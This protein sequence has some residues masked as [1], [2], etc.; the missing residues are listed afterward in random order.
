M[1]QLLNPRPA[2]DA[3]QTGRLTK[4]LQLSRQTLFELDVTITAYVNLAHSSVLG[5][6]W[7]WRQP[8]AAVSLARYALGQHVLSTITE[9]RS[10]CG[11]ALAAR[12]LLRARQPALSVLACRMGVW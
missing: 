10:E 2:P 9:A 8:A 11:A 5:N 4:A 3:L 12:L 7:R 6:M 1:R